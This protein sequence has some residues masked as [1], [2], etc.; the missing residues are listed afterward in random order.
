[1]NSTAGRNI[2]ALYGKK[3]IAYANKVPRYYRPAF[4]DIDDRIRNLVL[5]FGMRTVIWNI[6]ADDAAGFKSVSNSTV[7]ANGT[8]S[9]DP[10]AWTSLN[11]TRRFFDTINN[12]AMP[13]PNTNDSLSW[14]PNNPI[15]IRAGAPATGSYA[16]FISLEHETEEAQFDAARVVLSLVLDG[17][18]PPPGTVT[19]LGPT[20]TPTN[21]VV[22]FPA[23]NAGRK[24][25]AGS[26]AECD[27]N[28]TA[29]YLYFE[30]SDPLVAFVRGIT[31]PVREEEFAP[32]GVPTST[33]TELAAAATSVGSSSLGLASSTSG[34]TTKA[35]VPVTTLTPMATTTSGARGAPRWAVCV[36][37]AAGLAALAAMV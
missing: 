35:P 19:G 15:A 30:D 7:I 23:V 9:L 12:G 2:L 1:M 6:L 16:G 28:A 32:T 17:V 8:R 21:A 14:I 27:G 37:A 13:I 4:G 22:T 31:L 5:A 34:I 10:T 26:V 3:A 25:R 33:T 11:V 29:A 36:V 18:A 20:A 24:F